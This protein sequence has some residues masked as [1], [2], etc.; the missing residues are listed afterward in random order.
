MGAAS[1]QVVIASVSVVVPRP[2]TAVDLAASTCVKQL[3]GQVE[4]GLYQLSLQRMVELKGSGYKLASA[5]SA[6]DRPLLVLI[7]DLA[8]ST[9]ASFG[10]LWAGPPENVRALFSAY[11]G[12]VYGL[13]HQ[14]LGASVLSNALTLAQALPQG[15]RLHL[16]GH[17]RGGLVAEVLALSAGPRKFD[18]AVDEL[19]LT[20]PEGRQGRFEWKDLAKLMDIKRLQ[21]DRVVRIATPARGSLLASKR[22][23]FFL[24]MLRW[25][26]T[27]ER[28]P[29]PTALT[30]LI[31]E[32]ARRR[33]DPGLLPGLADLLPDSPLIG[34]LN[35]SRDQ[36]PGDLRV[37]AG[38]CHGSPVTDWA[39]NMVADALLQPEGDLLFGGRSMYGG[40]TRLG[41]ALFWQASGPEHSHFHYLNN[42]TTAG[43]VLA[44]LLE[45]QP[46]GF[47]SIGPLSWAGQSSSGAL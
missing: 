18:D 24:S 9:T 20:G 1:G 28:L 3:D 2:D 47:E 10:G 31:Y 36:I 43:A 12:R 23:D 19:M 29:G 16:L 8:V 32:V 39:A 33:A 40:P 13:E 4:E 21:V 7:H 22:L 44:A 37:I 38:T 46:K 6:G 30:A 27:R 42:P 11:G 14:T 17:G 34:W 15:A 26:I 35:R 45:A 41:S 5:P 25:C